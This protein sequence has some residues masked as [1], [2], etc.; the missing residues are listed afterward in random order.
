MNRSIS[1]DEERRF[2]G[3]SK[4]QCVLSLRCDACRQ[5]SLAFW[6]LCIGNGRDVPG[7]ALVGRAAA[8]AAALSASLA[9]RA[10]ATAWNWKRCAR[11]GWKSWISSGR[12]SE[13]CACELEGNKVLTV[14]Y[15]PWIVI[16]VGSSLGILYAK[17]A[18][19]CWCC[20][21]RSIRLGTRVCAATKLERLRMRMLRGAD[22]S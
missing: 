13:C 18:D 9:T 3:A 12:K 20:K 21:L 7:V 19:E 16:R 2:G 1:L 8:A 11:E 5:M 6:M 17:L 22:P 14:C 10:W 4:S 15:E